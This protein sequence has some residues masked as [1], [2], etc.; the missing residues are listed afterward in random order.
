MS[1]KWHVLFS[2]PEKICLK[3]LKSYMFF[4][5]KKKGERL[6]ECSH[7]AG[8]SGIIFLCLTKKNNEAYN[9]NHRCFI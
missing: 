8:N 4:I 7:V 1:G 2:A 9:L 3:I 5:K 6:V